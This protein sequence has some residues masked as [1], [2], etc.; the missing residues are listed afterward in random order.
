MIDE[1]IS[2]IRKGLYEYSQHAVDQSILR[3]ISNKEIS[4]AIEHGKIIE[5][6]PDDKYGPSCLICGVTQG[7]RILHVQCSV[8]PVWIITTYDPTLNPNEWEDNFKR[9]RKQR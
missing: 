8:D 2:K 5:D 7:G 9:R 1:I 4:E 3:I 6:Y